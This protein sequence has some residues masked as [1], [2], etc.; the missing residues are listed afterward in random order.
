MVGLGEEKREVQQV[1]DDMRSADI[2]FLTIGQY[3]QPTPRHHQG[4]ALRR[5]RGVRGLCPLARA[6]GFL[7]VSASPL[8]RSS[9]H[10]GDDFARLR[11]ARQAQQGCDAEGCARCR[12]MPRSG[13]CPIA[14][15]SSTS[16]SPGSTAIPEFL[17]WCKAARITRREGDVFY[18]DLV[19][20]FKVFRERFSSKVTLHPQI[21]VDVEYINGP[22]RYLKNHWQFAPAP[23]RLPGRLLCRLRVQVEDPAEPDRAAVQRGGAPHGGCVRDPG[24]AALHAGRGRPGDPQLVEQ[25][26]IG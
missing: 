16:W 2:D 23:G 24:T 6:K 18:A 14:P 12:P 19:I 9:Y 17:P 15:S 25:P 7:Q 26:A 5:A 3:L 4:D 21:R 20:A 8:T 11:A 1:M 10:A 13:C 22:F